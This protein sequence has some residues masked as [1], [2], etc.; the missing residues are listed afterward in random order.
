[1]NAQCVFGA[2]H[3]SK[4]SFGVIMPRLSNT[5]NAVAIGQLKAGVPQNQ[6]AARLG[7][8]PSTISKW[9]AKFGEP[10]MSRTNQEVGIPRKQHRP[11]WLH[12]VLP[13]TAGDNDCC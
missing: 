7:V 4:W 6:I 10:V 8:S 13:P 12:M 11:L 5:E 3:Y 2:G 1:M 9:K